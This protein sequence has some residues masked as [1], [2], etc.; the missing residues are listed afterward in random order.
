MMCSE[1]ALRAGAGLVT[2]YAHESTYAILATAASPE[3]MVK[4]VADYRGL[5]DDQLDVVAIGPGLGHERADEVLEI[6]ESDLRPMVV[7]AD[8]L[9]I[10]AGAGAD[11]VLKKCGGPRLLTP[12]PGEMARLWSEMPAGLGRREAARDFVERNGVTLLWKGARTLVTEK[13]RAA[14]YNSTGHPG[15]ASGGMGDVLTG[16]AAGWVAQG[17]GVYDAGC[18][19]SWLL[20]RG[21]ELACRME[22]V[23]EESVTAT[24]VIAQLGRAT[25][26]L[27]WGGS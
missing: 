19:A 16:I 8:A 27:K 11:E 10:I 26:E 14:A 15:M 21:A 24:D 22:G 3:V 7:D 4:P 5:L 2:L 9:N 23:A 25:A 12:H 13:G 20:G 17:L 18:V 6:V 1:A